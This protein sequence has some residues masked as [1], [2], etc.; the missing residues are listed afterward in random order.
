MASY[1]AVRHVV[2]GQYIPTGSP[3][4]RLD[5]RAKL[6]AATVVVAAVIAATSYVSNV[7]LLSFVLALVFL[8]QLPLRY[9]LSGVTPA[10]PVIAILALVQLLLYRGGSADS[11][12]MVSY[13]PI[14]IYAAGV[15]LVVVSLLRFLDLLFVTS[16]LTSTTTTS[17]LTHGL[18][19]LLRPFS[20]IGLPGHEIALVGAIALRF[21]PILGE[22][23]E[24]IIKAQAS[25]GASYEA[26]GRWRLVANARRMAAIA[27]PLFVDAYRRSEELALAMQARCYRG[28]RGRTH[29][30]E[31]TLT[32]VDFIAVGSAAVILVAVGIIQY[33][34]FA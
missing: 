19:S 3:I 14:H 13:G 21:V 20:A 25:R 22:Q 12:A 5:P 33:L 4:H 28:G 27:V 32:P 17:A 18:E 24:S 26:Q 34:S 8:A 31:L 15:R 29:L 10:L 23:L 16:L 7:L 6:I 1:D 11:T 30:V 9:I 2:I